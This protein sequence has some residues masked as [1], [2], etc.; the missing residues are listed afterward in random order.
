M[1]TFAL[2][3][4]RYRVTATRGPEFTVDQRELTVAVGETKLDLAVRRV[5]DSGRWV[6]CDLHVHSSTSFDSHVSPE[7]RARALA[8]A[9]VAFGAPTEHDAV[10]SYEGTRASARGLRWA[11]AMEV[12]PRAP[13]V[14]HFTI[15]PYA[16]ETA[17]N[18]RSVAA[19]RL[20]RELRA[21]NPEALIQ[22]NH[23]R[24]NAGM[25][26]FNIIRLDVRKSLLTDLLPAQVD[27][28]EV[29]N[30]IELRK[31]AQTEQV[32]REWMALM[33]SG[34]GRWATAGSDVH[35]EL[36]MPGFPRSY[37]LPVADDTR[38]LIK[39]LRTGHS[40]ATSAPF[41]ELTQGDQGPGG[42]ATVTN[43]KATV[44][45]KLQAA[46][47]VDVRSVEVWSGGR[48][49]WRRDL[50]ERPVRVGPPGP[51]AAAERRA[52]VLVDEDVSVEV[53]FAARTILAV[54]RGANGTSTL[55][56]SSTS[57]AARRSA[58]ASG[59]GGPTRTGRSGR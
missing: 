24:L 54:A 32:F 5:V 40:F 1:S 30:G 58:A 37:A 3:P 50:P 11:P 29:L 14:G 20:L 19:S 28:I 53:P 18:T 22:I 10:G 35:H 8:A 21:G 7:A 55:T 52:A 48:V 12:T 23:P 15:V 47:W 31:P 2:G 17:P 44:H 45:V 25:G 46:P 26:Y 38:S 16:G 34:H 36:Q 39:A 27:T 4:G 43:G 49:V 13:A 41:L 56:S 6:S 57:T 51:D 9:G 33:E 59:P 42:R